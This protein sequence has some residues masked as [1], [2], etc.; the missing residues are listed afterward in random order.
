MRCL[1]LKSHELTSQTFRLP[2]SAR[3]AT[4]RENS[5][6]MEPNEISLE[7]MKDRIKRIVNGLP[8]PPVSAPKLK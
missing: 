2:F 1:I 4:L 8:E 5:F 7:R 6:F 3:S